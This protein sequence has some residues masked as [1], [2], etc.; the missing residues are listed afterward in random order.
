M[1]KYYENKVYGY[2]LYFTSLCVI[3]AMHASDSKKYQKEAQLNFLS[4]VMVQQL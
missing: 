4:E 2:Y 1:P 3:E